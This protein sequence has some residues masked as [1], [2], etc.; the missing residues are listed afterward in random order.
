MNFLGKQESKWIHE[1]VRKIHVVEKGK[2]KI[3]NTL[4]RVL[5][6][7]LLFSFPAQY[8]DYF[9]QIDTLLMIR[10]CSYNGNLLIIKRNLVFSKVCFFFLIW[11]NVLILFC[12]RF[13]IVFNRDYHYVDIAFELLNVFFIFSVFNIGRT[14]TP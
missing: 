8:G 1:C 7:S 12:K 13:R 6:L 3:G 10:F 2:I 4:K 5:S 9:W 11:I 14:F